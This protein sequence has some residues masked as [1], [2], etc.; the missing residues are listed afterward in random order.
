M[1]ICYNIKS[2]RICL[3]K[4]FV[5][6]SDIDQLISNGTVFIMHGAVLINNNDLNTLIIIRIRMN[7]ITVRTVRKQQKQKN[8]QKKKLCTTSFFPFCTRVITCVPAVK[9]VSLLQHWSATELNENGLAGI[10]GEK[11]ER[12]SDVFT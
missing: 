6:I 3:V 2:N 4:A 1:F 11:M 7:G 5:V 12:K 10:G 8:K 9:T